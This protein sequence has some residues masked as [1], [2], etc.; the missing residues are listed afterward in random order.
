MWHA[1]SCS[2]N[3]RVAA[4]FKK[5]EADGALLASRTPRSPAESPGLNAPEAIAQ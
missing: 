5:G 4:E 1:G 3:D 2:R